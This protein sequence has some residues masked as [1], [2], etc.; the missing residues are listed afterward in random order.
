MSARPVQPSVPALALTKA[1]AAAALHMSIS[2]FERHVQPHLGF[3]TSGGKLL[4]P[5]AELERWVD[6]EQNPPL[7]RGPLRT[8]AK[9]RSPR[10]RRGD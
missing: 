7:V 5:V 9:P 10:V 4:F 1:A 6:Q 3:I 2:H 8:H